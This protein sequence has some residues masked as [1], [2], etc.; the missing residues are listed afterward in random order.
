MS[1][2]PAPSFWPMRRSITSRMN[3]KTGNTFSP[4]NGCS[5]LCTMPICRIRI[6]APMAVFRMSA[7]DACP[8]T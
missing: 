5:K 8:S 2:E 3:P 1:S 7:T 6:G 4:V